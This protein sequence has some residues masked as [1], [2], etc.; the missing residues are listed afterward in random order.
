[1]FNKEM[2]DAYGLDNPYD[3]VRNGSW[4]IDKF[5]AMAQTVLSD[6][7][8]DGNMTRAADSWGYMSEPKQVFPCFWISAGEMSIAKDERDL[9]YL[10]ITGNDRFFAIFDKV[11]SVMW[12][13][14]V[15]CCDQKNIDHWPET[16][17]MFGESR[18][19]FVDEIFYRLNEL[20]DVEAAFGII[21]YP[22]FDDT[23]AEYYSRVE[24]GA[25][26]GMVP[27]TNKHPEYAGA[28]LEAMSSFGYNHLIPE[29]YEVALK[30]RTSRDSESAEMLD[31]IFATRRYDLGDTWWC[32][33][34][35][36]GLF[37]NMFAENDRNLASGIAGQ[38]KIINKTLTKVVD[39]LSG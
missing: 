35:R 31:L 25:R 11:Y 37:K 4:N 39:K 38:E 17:K 7:D 12:D 8:G 34:L 13:D 18:V 15:W 20:R 30:R 5:A 21:P 32:N 14:G 6:A 22:M 9:P 19:L 33:E 36:D 24:A 28:L 16:A 2:I 10:N 1:M 26:I 29:Y 3:L 27:I 23:Q